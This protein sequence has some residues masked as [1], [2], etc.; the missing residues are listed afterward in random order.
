MGDLPEPRPREDAEDQRNEPIMNQINR[1]IGKAARQKRLMM[2]KTMTKKSKLSSGNVLNRNKNI[3]IYKSLEVNNHY[4]Q[5]PEYLSETLF[6]SFTD[7]PTSRLDKIHFIVGSG[8]IRPELRTEIFCQ[9]CKQL[10][11][12]PSR[13]SKKGGWLLLSLCLGCF[14]PNEQFEKYLRCFIRQNQSDL[15]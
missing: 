1:T 7:R 9:I 4:Y 6:R 10:T 15:G 8:I 2:T 12:N 14:G 5:Y 3:K 11:Q 13:Q